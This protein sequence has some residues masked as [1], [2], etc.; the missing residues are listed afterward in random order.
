M[1]HVKFPVM[2]ARYAFF[3][4]SG[5]D[6]EMTR[7]EVEMSNGRWVVI[8]RT[9]GLAL[10]EFLPMRGS[11]SWKPRPLLISRNGIDLDAGACPHTPS[12]HPTCVGKLS[13]VQA[14][15]AQGHRDA[16]E[17]EVANVSEPLGRL[18][19]GADC[20]ADEAPTGLLV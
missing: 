19:A 17:C 14:W 10:R 16:K 8:D 1:V 2:S 15:I 4:K 9:T 13:Q 18:R 6:F 20:V 12:I 5:R 11:P 7:Y 3:A